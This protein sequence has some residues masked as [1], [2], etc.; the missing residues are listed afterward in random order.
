MGEGAIAG[1]AA[2]CLV[3]TISCFLFGF[4]F[5]TIEPTEM[6]LIFDANLQHL[7][8][9]ETYLSGRYF[10]G[11]GKEFITFP[12]TYQSIRFGSSFSDRDHGSVTCRARDG[13]LILL[14]GAFQFKLSE[15]PKDLVRLYMDHGEEYRKQ[16]SR[17]ALQSIRVVASNYKAKEYFVKR[18]AIAEDIKETIA[19]DLGQM[20]TTVPSFQLTNMEFNDALA[21]KIEETQERVQDV[22]QAGYE[23]DVAIIEAAQELEV[24]IEVAK[25]LVAQ[26]QADANVTLAEAEADAAI[27]ID[28]A[29]QAVTGYQLLQSNLGL[30]STG[31]LLNYLWVN[32]VERSQVSKLA[33][34]LDIPSSFQI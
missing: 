13:L 18:N 25:V 23:M 34:A 11:L 12:R 26:A 10:T 29:N 17:M 20:Y 2:F 14:D 28:R 22:E 9:D 8:F 7:A 30:N 21:R 24:A 6:G 4:S 16:F 5:D 27:M 32:A 19:R 15:D 1:G 33:L 3:F 31:G